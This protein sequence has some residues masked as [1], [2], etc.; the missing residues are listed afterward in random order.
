[1]KKYCF[2]FGSFEYNGGFALTPVHFSSQTK[3]QRNFIMTSQFHL[4]IYLA[5]LLQ[6]WYEKPCRS[7]PLFRPWQWH[8]KKWIIKNELILNLTHV[9]YLGNNSISRLGW[10]FFSSCGFFSVRERKESFFSERLISAMTI[11]KRNTINIE[12]TI[13]KTSFGHI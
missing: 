4:E 9:P 10:V 13:N 3:W 6:Q 2:L 8:Q 1:M 12:I 7:K 5:Q 11:T